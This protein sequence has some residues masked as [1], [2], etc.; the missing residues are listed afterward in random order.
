VTASAREGG[1]AGLG[2]S[3]LVALTEAEANKSALT[4]GYRDIS[5]SYLETTE[6]T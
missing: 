2:R 4:S 3:E 1:V 5:L 6:I